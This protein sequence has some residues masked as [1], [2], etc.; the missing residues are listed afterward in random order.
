MICPVCRR[1]LPATFALATSLSTVVCRGCSAELRPTHDSASLVARKTFYPFAAVGVALGSGGVWYGLSTDR[2]TALWIAL[3]M[4]V[5]VSIA[6]SWWVATKFYV[7][8]R[9]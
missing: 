4:G 1:H 3:S 2:W 5:V 8:E 9:A 7:F 6:I